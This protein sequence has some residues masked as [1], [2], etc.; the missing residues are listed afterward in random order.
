MPLC[1][2]EVV[3]QVKSLT[4][5]SGIEHFEIIGYYWPKAPE[6]IQ[7]TGNIKIIIMAAQIFPEKTEIH[8]VPSQGIKGPVV[9]AAL[10]AGPGARERLAAR[11]FEA[12]AE[13]APEWGEA[14]KWG[15]LTLETGPLGQPL[16]TLGGKTGP[17]VSFSAEGGLLWA[18]VSGTGQVGVDAAPEAD[19][20]PPYPYSRAF[21]QEEWD[22]AVRHC[23]GRPASAA[24]LL[25]AAK[26]A[27]VKALG[28]G[29]H[30][31]DP[32]DLEV[33]SPTPAGEGVSLVVRT[34]KP[35]N[36]WARPLPDGWL[37]LAVA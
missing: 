16:L 33:S 4:K 23:P 25:W 32:L 17:G 30:T 12:L 13:I 19:F 22:L 11:L 31:L 10:A 28:V 6:T 3:L 5:F 14:R 9:Y 35:L 29:F 36:A 21:G 20:A 37:A 18:A 34:P 8:L 7:R 24:A 27:A 2:G 26:E 1:G 15:P